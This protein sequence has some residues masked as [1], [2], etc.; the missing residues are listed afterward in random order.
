MVRYG[1]VGS[2]RLWWGTVWWGHNHN[3]VIGGLVR[4]GMAGSGAVWRGR[5]RSYIKRFGGD[6]NEKNFKNK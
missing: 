1:M 5:V 2:G 6:E 3:H 4:Y